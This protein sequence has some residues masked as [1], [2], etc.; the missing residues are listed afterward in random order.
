MF[1]SSAAS[2]VGTNAYVA[3]ASV[4]TLSGVGFTP[5]SSGQ[6][7]APF[8]ANVPGA[9]TPRNLTAKIGFGMGANSYMSSFQKVFDLQV[10]GRNALGVVPGSANDAGWQMPQLSLN[11][12]TGVLSGSAMRWGKRVG[13][14]GVLLQQTVSGGN[15]PSG[16][17]NAYGVGLTSDGDPFVLT[18]Q[19]P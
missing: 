16:L 10:S 7:L 5:A 15:L 9:N 18:E 4:G 19:T 8:V 17:Q 3:F 14:Q 6:T 1:E 13:L 12:A 2:A 11:P